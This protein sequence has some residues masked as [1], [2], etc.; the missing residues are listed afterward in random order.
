MTTYLLATTHFG[1]EIYEA[2]WSYCF[3][4]VI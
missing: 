1:L 3:D 2:W 4:L